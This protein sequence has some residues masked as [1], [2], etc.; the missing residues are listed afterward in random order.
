[1]ETRDAFSLEYDLPQGEAVH[2]FEARLLPLLDEQVIAIVRDI[3]ERKHAESTLR[4]SEALKASILETAL[5]AIITIDHSD[6]V[7]EFNPV[8]EQVFGYA[9]EEI[10]GRE[11]SNCIVPPDLREGHLRGIRHYLATGVGPV[12]NKRIEVPGMRKDGT[13]FPMELAVTPILSVG[14]PMFTAYIRD[15][16]DRRQAEEAL[17]HA[18]EDAERARETAEAANRAKSE[19]LS[20]MSHELRTPMNSILGFAQVLSRKVAPEHRKSTEHILKAGRHLL[21]LI[22]EV[23]DIARIESKRMQ[24]SPEP[25]RVSHIV[26]ETLTLI[27]PLAIQYDCFVRDEISN[28]CDFYVLADRQR[29]TQVLLN[30]VSNAVKY[31]REKGS[32]VLACETVEDN[33]LRLK[34]TDTGAGL[35]PDQIARLFSPFER[36][37]ADQS[38]VE[39]TG[40]GLALSKGLV[41]VMGGTMGVSSVPGEGSTFW[42][43]LA[44]VESPQE[45]LQRTREGMHVQIEGSGK[46]ATLLYIEDNLANLSLIETILTDRSEFLLLSAMQGQLGLELAWEHNPDI[47]LLDLHLPDISGDEVLVRLR[48]DSRTQNIPVIVI[49]ADATP[50]HIKEVM[51]AGAQAYL[52]KPLDVD[53]FLLTVDKMLEEKQ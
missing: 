23:L 35:T 44:L 16:T 6:H 7:V 37:G 5:D 50:S 21:D 2:S 3:T 53:Q 52:T 24:L 8:A 45:R 38:G 11:L 47:I 29:L 25:V 14:P 15:I 42:V 49:S 39:G 31:N 17:R 32:V 41:E 9:R 4:E 13:I 51:A 30:L 10:V 18:K 46:E 48:Q 19:F 27:Q 34:I 12:L 40:L 33:R 43:E 28:Q 26:Q 36:L 1:L 20:R 22:N